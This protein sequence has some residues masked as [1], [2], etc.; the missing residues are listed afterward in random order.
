MIAPLVVK[1]EG[2]F[3]CVNNGV[4]C[5]NSTISL[6]KFQALREYTIHARH[7]SKKILDEIGLLEFWRNLS[8]ASKL[9]ILFGI[10]WIDVSVGAYLALSEEI[11]LMSEFMLEFM[12]RT[13]LYTELYIAALALTGVIMAVWMYRDR[14]DG[15][16]RVIVILSLAANVVVC[17]MMIPFPLLLLYWA[18]FFLLILWTMFYSSGK[19]GAALGKLLGIL[20][21]LLG[22][23]PAWEIFSLA[24]DIR[25]M[26]HLFFVSA[27]IRWLTGA[28]FIKDARSITQ[29]SE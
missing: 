11:F 6:R 9:G 15:F 29:A 23:F 16:L 18:V 8:L 2:E 24:G 3:L 21:I 25:K 5:Y 26:T 14:P 17:F 7:I 12:S 22:L 19:F 1:A 10:M 4:E 13:I 27:L 20:Y 28:Y